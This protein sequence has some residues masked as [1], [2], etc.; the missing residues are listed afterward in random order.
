MK[1]YLGMLLSISKAI[2]IVGIGYGIG[3]AAFVDLIHFIR[4]LPVFFQILLVLIVIFL[5]TFIF[6]KNK[7]HKKEI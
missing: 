3:S 7:N 2:L 6:I 4:K 1:S 5:I